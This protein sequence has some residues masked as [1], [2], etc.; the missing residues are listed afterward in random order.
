[1]STAARGEGA[2]CAVGEGGA[3][4]VTEPGGLE[5]PSDTN[6]RCPLFAAAPL[7][8]VSVVSVT[9]DKSCLAETHLATHDIEHEN[10]DA[11]VAVEDAARSLNNLPIARLPHLRRS[12][13]ALWLFHKL[14]DVL[15]NSLNK[16][17]RRLRVIE[18]DVI[19]DGVEVMESRF[20]PD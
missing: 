10:S 6:R 7:L 2:G 1:M 18:S 19:S 17:P 4:P 12:G 15:K 3:Q 13:T 9:P 20:S 5:P 8:G 16:T 14:L 11:I